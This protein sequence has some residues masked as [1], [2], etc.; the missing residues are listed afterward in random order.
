M[1]LSVQTWYSDFAA[2]HCS[3]GHIQELKSVGA[4]WTT[5][6][7]STL[8]SAAPLLMGKRQRQG[9]ATHH[10]RSRE[11]LN[12]MEPW[13]DEA[14]RPDCPKNLM[15]SSPF[16][17]LLLICAVV[18]LSGRD[19]MS[20]LPWASSLPGRTKSSPSCV[21]NAKVSSNSCHILE[22]FAGDINQWAIKWFRPQT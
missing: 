3:L 10:V 8:S 11:R 17:V 2:G 21:W 4:L 9:V 1:M 16:F 22:F 18:T 19:H 12:W 14:F 13:F 6:W 20:G 5:G 15:Y 7:H